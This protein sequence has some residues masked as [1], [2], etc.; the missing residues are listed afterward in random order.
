MQFNIFHTGAIQMPLLKHLNFRNFLKLSASLALLGSFCM[1][2]I[3]D[4][5]C[6]P[7]GPIIL[8]WSNDRNHKYLSI[9][10]MLSCAWNCTFLMISGSWN[11]TFFKTISL[12]SS[13][14]VSDRGLKESKRLYFKSGD[15]KLQKDAISFPEKSFI[16]CSFSNL[17]LNFK[18][19][20]TS[21]Y[22]TRKGVFLT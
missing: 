19:F 4:R 14:E 17:M 18:D 3:R 10:L 8:V 1:S 21:F 5:A 9:F 20:S 11:K 12:T 2:V 13:K 6:K 22:F 7:L 16:S 15:W